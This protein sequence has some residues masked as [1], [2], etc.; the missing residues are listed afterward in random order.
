MAADGQRTH[1][2]DLEA[3]ARPSA[4]LVPRDQPSSNKG[5]PSAAN[6][7]SRPPKRNRSCF[8]KCLCWSRRILSLVGSIVVVAAATL[9]ILY[10]ILCLIDPKDPKYSV[11]RLSISAFSVDKDLNVN[12]AFNVT[13]TATNPNKRIG[14]YYVDGSEVN[15]LYA[16]TRL[17][18][19][20]FPVF[21][22]GHRNMTVMA[23]MLNGQVKVGSELLNGL[24]E[25]QRTGMVPLTFKGV[26]P[27]KVKFGALKLWKVTERVTCDLVV[28]SLSVS[29]QISIKTSTFMLFDVCSILETAPTLPDFALAL[30][31][32][33]YELPPVDR[34]WNKEE[35]NQQKD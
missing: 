34:S 32:D 29:N 7:H 13:V 23:L 26:V 19:G 6:S 27:V 22:Q 2:F 8:Y 14:I 10:L 18:S 20:E 16:G 17:C 12:A 35:S 28:N 30:K 5:D 31:P 24:Q 15:V 33:D 25:Q 3:G 9:G 21:Y 11:N 4:P 1:T